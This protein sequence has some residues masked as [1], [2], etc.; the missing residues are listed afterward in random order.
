[1][2]MLV[3]VTADARGQKP[4]EPKG[5]ERW[6]RIIDSH[7]ASEAMALT[8]KATAGLIDHACKPENTGFRER[9]VHAIVARK[10]SSL[11]FMAENLHPLEASVTLAM[12]AAL[13]DTAGDVDTWKRSLALLP[14]P[15]RLAILDFA[16]S[17]AGRIRASRLASEAIL[18]TSVMQPEVMS[19]MEPE[20]S[21]LH[22]M[23]AAVTDAPEDVERWG[24][25]LALLAPEDVAASLVMA[26]R[27]ADEHTTGHFSPGISLTL[28]GFLQH[29]TT[30][31]DLGLLYTMLYAVD[32]AGKG[33]LVA[34]KD[35]PVRKTAEKYM[36]LA[37]Q[38]GDPGERLSFP[39]AFSLGA[40]APE[41]QVFMANAWARAMTD[42]HSPEQI[43]ALLSASAGEFPQG[44]PL[45]RSALKIWG[46]A[47]NALDQEKLG[48]W[49]RNL[50][51]K[52][53]NRATAWSLPDPEK[54]REK[55]APVPG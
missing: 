37:E 46:D 17:L 3:R 41:M 32:S 21:R 15:A 44:H 43:V 34:R 10:L 4:E 23:I 54:P 19:E 39:C 7:P 50:R 40:R 25:S 8:R 14:L 27:H 52:I 18:Q 1:M 35:S 22:A 6:F 45:K 30:E 5:A 2:T 12:V 29:M 31:K 38:R 49:E 26:I 36:H 53:R 13:T 42:F 47:Q 33:H 20:I 28:K 55:S 24:Q 9:P 48:P 51:A 11:T 16:G